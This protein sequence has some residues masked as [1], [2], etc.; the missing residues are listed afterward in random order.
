MVKVLITFPEELREKVVDDLKKT[1][2]QAKEY[3]KN[4]LLKVYAKFFSKVMKV[5]DLDVAECSF[6]FIGKNKIVW[7]YWVLGMEIMSEEKLFEIIK[8]KIEKDYDGKVKVEL[9]KNTKKI[10]SKK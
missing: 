10:K 4:K 1:V 7:D 3:N 9:Y 5:K 6:K 2:E 8:K